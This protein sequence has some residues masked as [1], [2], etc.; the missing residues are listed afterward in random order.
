MMNHTERVSKAVALRRD[1]KG[2][3]E[4]EAATGMLPHVARY[5]VRQQAPELIG[6]ISAKPGPPPGSR[7]TWDNSHYNLKPRP[8]RPIPLS[9]LTGAKA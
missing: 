7:G 4:I 9:R 8:I 6:A 2:W 5:Y 1:G 3:P